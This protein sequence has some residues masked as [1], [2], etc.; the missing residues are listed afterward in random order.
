MRVIAVERKVLNA[1][2]KNDRK[3]WKEIE[4]K[5][6]V[7]LSLAG[8]E[9]ISVEAT[10]LQQQGAEWMAEKVLEAL[11]LGFPC[12]RAIKLFNDDYYLEVLDLDLIMRRNAKQITRYKARVIGSG[13]KA[14]SKIE[15]LTGAF[16][17]V[18]DDKI[19]LI[20]KY[21]ELSQAKEAVTRLLEGSTHSSVYS[22]LERKR[23]TSF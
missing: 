3:A 15:E 2:Q 9:S 22:F 1:L 10:D 14:K 7:R 12:S 16:L 17:S 23:K 5:G 4:R 11:S 19:G 13:G 6:G 8:E 21:D 20:G 18:A